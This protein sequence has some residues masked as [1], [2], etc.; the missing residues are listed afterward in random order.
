MRRLFG[1]GAIVIFLAI[2]LLPLTAHAVDYTLTGWV[3]DKESFK[4]IPYVHYEIRT[5]NGTLV[6]YKTTDNNGYFYVILSAGTYVITIFTKEYQPLSKLITIHNDL[7]IKFYLEPVNGSSSNSEGDYCK[8]VLLTL[9]IFL[10]IFII[11]T[12]LL[13]VM[14]WDLKKKVKGNKE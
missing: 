10:T 5:Q 7:E 8:P 3:Y 12:E 6:Y 13:A 14:Y 4:P 11:S 9:S 2:A 1:I